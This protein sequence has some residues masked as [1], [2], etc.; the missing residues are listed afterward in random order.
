MGGD[1][2]G[3]RAGRQNSL[4][5]ICSLKVF[6]IGDAVSTLQQKDNLF[7]GNK[8]FCLFIWGASQKDV[9]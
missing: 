9:V 2:R 8:E 7:V 3:A 4:A 5:G 6:L 1:C